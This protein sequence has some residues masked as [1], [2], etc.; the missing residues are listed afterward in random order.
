MLDDLRRPAQG[1]LDPVF[2]FVMPVVAPI[3]PDMAQT[4]KY[5]LKCLREEEFDAV[6]IHDISR[7]NGRFEHQ[8]FGVH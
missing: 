7:M 4:R 2:A 8:S 5:V 6:A 3:E 1:L